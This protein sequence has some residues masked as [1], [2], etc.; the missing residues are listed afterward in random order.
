MTTTLSR[1][2]TSSFIPCAR[3]FRWWRIRWL[4]PR[5]GPR[6]P[7]RPSKRATSWTA[8]SSSIRSPRAASPTYPWGVAG[9][10]A[11]STTAQ[12]TALNTEAE[13]PARCLRRH[14]RPCAGRRR[15]PG[16]AGKLRSRRQ[17]HRRLH[18]GQ[19]SARTRYCRH[20]AAGHRSYASRRHSV[21][22]RAVGCRRCNTARASA[23]LPS[24][25]GS[26]ACCRRSTKLPAP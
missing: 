8:R 15:L 3:P 17:H 13:R 11:V 18:H 26:R 23:N 12:Q 25:T 7:S 10:P 5:P 9:L 4:R 24:T 22:L 6:S 2:S 14:R 20:V 1:K 19:L 21:S 16:G